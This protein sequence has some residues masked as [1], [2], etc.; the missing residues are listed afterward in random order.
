MSELNQK[1]TKTENRGGARPGAGRPKGS[2]DKVSVSSLL[3]ALDA[4]SHGQSYEE[5][6]IEDFLKARLSDDN[7]AVIKYHNL[8]LNKVMA[9]LNHVEVT[10]TSEAVAAK[11]AAFTEALRAL[12]N[13]TEDSK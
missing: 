5:I 10:D 4:K 9:T 7:Q 8:I 11:Q 3:E 6:L 13:N 12:Q 1:Q 2:R